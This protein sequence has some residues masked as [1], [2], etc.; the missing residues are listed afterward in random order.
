[1]SY[2][3]CD[4]VLYVIYFAGSFIVV[5]SEIGWYAALYLLIVGGAGVH[6]GLPW[7]LCGRH[8]M[9]AFRLPAADVT[10]CGWGGLS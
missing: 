9:T 6:T 1:M 4:V 8:K 3:V 7:R 5:R 2:L 10:W